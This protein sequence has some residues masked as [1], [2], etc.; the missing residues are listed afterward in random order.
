MTN[1]IQA[2]SWTTCRILPTIV[3]ILFG[4]ASPVTSQ[5]YSIPSQT[6]DLVKDD[7]YGSSVDFLLQTAYQEIMLLHSD[8]APTVVTA[9]LATLP[10]FQTLQIQWEQETVLALVALQ[11][12][13]DGLTAAIVTTATVAKWGGSV[14][15]CGPYA[16][17]CWIPITKIPDVAKLSSVKFV[18]AEARL[19]RQQQQGSIRNEALVAHR[20]HDVRL[21]IDPHLTGAGL[22]IGVLSDSYDTSTTSATKAADDMASGDLPPGGVTVLRDSPP[23]NGGKDEG[24]AMMQLIHDIAPGAELVFRTAFLGAQDFANGIGELADAGCDVIVGTVPYHVHVHCLI[25]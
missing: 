25:V 3:I 23:R 24:R 10:V 1:P 21:R 17:T 4:S 16:C 12:G 19:V 9:D 8:N 18:R 5:A 2:S 6:I 11:E 20:V 13:T 15:T 7:Q 14:V 22:K